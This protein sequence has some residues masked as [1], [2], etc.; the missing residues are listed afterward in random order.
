MISQEIS[1]FI[2]YCTPFADPGLFFGD[3]SSDLIAK[4][5]KKPTIPKTILRCFPKIFL[6]L[7]KTAPKCPNFPSTGLKIRDVN[8]RGIIVTLSD[9][10]DRRTFWPPSMLKHQM[11]PFDVRGSN[12]Q[13][14]WEKEC[15][16]VKSVGAQ[17]ILFL[18]VCCLSISLYF[19]P[20]QPHP[21]PNPRNKLR[22]SFPK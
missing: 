18:S 9:E 17:C 2:A 11:A 5:L 3:Y 13:L 20:P 7:S 22:P 8:G 4:K 12:S 14:P 19:S 21:P 16:G 6:E 15:E 1:I 10:R